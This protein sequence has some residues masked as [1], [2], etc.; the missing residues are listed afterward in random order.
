MRLDEGDSVAVSDDAQDQ[1]LDAVK[2]A[3]PANDIRS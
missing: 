1:I 2:R 3:N